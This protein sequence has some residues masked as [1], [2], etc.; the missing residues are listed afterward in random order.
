MKYYKRIN[1]R[2]TSKKEVKGKEK[3]LEKEED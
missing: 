3:E 2:E 1:K